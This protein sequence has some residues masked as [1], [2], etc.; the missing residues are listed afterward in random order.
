MLAGLCQSVRT[1]Y[2]KNKFYKTPVA[3]YYFFQDDPE[4]YVAL[5]IGRKFYMSDKLKDKVDKLCS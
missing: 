2:T 3:N 1:E 4:E 5:F